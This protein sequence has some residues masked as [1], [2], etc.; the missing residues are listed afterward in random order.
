MNKPQVGVASCWYE[1]NPCN[2]H[3]LELARQV[4][5]G[6]QDEDLVAFRF[7]TVGVSDGMSMGTTGMR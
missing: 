1:G 3:L 4:K 6:V 7:N 2:M 5:I